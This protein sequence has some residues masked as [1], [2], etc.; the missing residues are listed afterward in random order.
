MVLRYL[1]PTCIEQARATFTRHS[2]PGTYEIEIQAGELGF[3]Q[4]THRANPC[5]LASLAGSTLPDANKLTTPVNHCH[6][7]ITLT[8]GAMS[9]A[10]QNG[11]DA[12]DSR[13]EVVDVS[14]R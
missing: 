1:D 12:D 2:H 10:A 9:S 11:I 7:A 5:A 13:R 3:D 8:R 4:S 6:R 14:C